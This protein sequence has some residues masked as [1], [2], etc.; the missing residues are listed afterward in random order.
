M[1]RRYIFVF[2]IMFLV[3]AVSPFFVMA[4]K[5]PYEGITINVMM[6]KF[7]ETLAFEKYGKQIAQDL[8]MELN[9]GWYTY[10]GTRQ[11]TILDHH[12]KTGNWDIVYL[13]PTWLGEYSKLNILEPV[14]KYF[15][16]LVN[17]DFN[18]DG[19]QLSQLNA[20]MK[21]DKLLAVPLLSANIIL[22]YRTDLFEDPI[23]KAAFKEKYGYELQVPETYKKFRDIAEF[24]TRKKGEK[25]LG[26][27]L[28]NSFYGTS[29][30]N[31]RGNFLWQDYLS[32][33]VAFGADVIF[34]P[35]TMM[36]TWNSPENIK[37]GE[38]Y[39][40]LVPFLP[41]GHINMTSGESTSLFASG[42]VA[43]IIEFDTR[44]TST[45]EDS[46]IGDKF[47]Y[48]LV[49][50]ANDNRK[51][52]YL[53]SPSSLGISTQS[54]HKEAAF[55]LI[56][57]FL[58]EKYQKLMTIDFPGYK[59]LRLAVAKDPEVVKKYPKVARYLIEIATEN[60]YTFGHSKIGI[61]PQA[62]EIASLSLSKA[63]AGQESVEKSFNEAQKKLEELFKEAGYIE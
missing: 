57:G 23:E 24:F 2:L 38:F 3:L 62:F 9:V 51:H 7:V 31:K 59:P 18:Y 41:P 60:P 46:E 20:L 13:V 58:S 5:S 32:Y 27:V 48:A 61:Y 35:K 49:P 17:P 44:V 29:H 14:D 36:P 4:E 42:K 11:K 12:N 55:K 6:P 40:S 54:K 33:A 43:M 56:E 28:E 15:K 52:A 8:G 37:A 45:V 53:L 26:K 22:A 30:S 63:L 34:D 16:E 21:G 1:K 25:L 50:S 39:V 47:D 19:L 10:D